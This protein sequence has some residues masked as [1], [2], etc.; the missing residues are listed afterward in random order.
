MGWPMGWPMDRAMGCPTF[1]RSHYATS[2]RKYYLPG[3]GY[4]I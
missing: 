4:P 1:H 2:Y 3:M